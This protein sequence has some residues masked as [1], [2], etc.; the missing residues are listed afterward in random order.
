MNTVV[1][2]LVAV[3]IIISIV[4]L[5]YQFIDMVK[6]DLRHEMYVENLRRDNKITL[7]ETRIE[8]LEQKQNEE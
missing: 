2:L 8:L 1:L 7:L 4:I 3:A 5:I 6:F